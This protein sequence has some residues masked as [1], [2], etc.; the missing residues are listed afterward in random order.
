MQCRGITKK[1]VSITSSFYRWPLLKTNTGQ[2]GPL[3]C[4]RNLYVMQYS[5]YFTDNFIEIR[6]NLA[7]I[8]FSSVFFFWREEIFL[9]SYT[10]LLVWLPSVGNTSQTVLSHSGSI[11][12]YILVLSLGLSCDSGLFSKFSCK[13]VLWY[14]R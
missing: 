3:F 10:A 1:L 7:Y 12:P 6:L 11:C 5:H 13:S 14:L 4:F 2:T 8:V 9:V